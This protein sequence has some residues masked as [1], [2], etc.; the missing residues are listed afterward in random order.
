MS[1]ISVRLPSYLHESIRDL[2]ERE[3]TSMNHIIVLALAEKLSALSAED[4]IGQRAKR[5]DR[6]KFEQ[7]MAH[8]PDVQPAA[9]DQL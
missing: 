9:H 5:G 3:K 6:V 7:A 8:V 4:Y 2:A 1:T